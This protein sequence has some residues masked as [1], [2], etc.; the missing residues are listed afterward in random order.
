MVDR[1]DA[2]RRPV[3]AMTGVPEYYLPPYYYEDEI[4]LRDYVNVLLKY[5]WLVLGVPLL[6]LIVAGIYGFLI[7]KPGYQATALVAITSPR[8]IVQFAPEFETVPLNQ[9]QVPLKAYPMLATSGELLQR[10]LPKV[11]ERLP[12]EQRTVTAL[13]SMVSAKSGQ[14][15]SIIELTVSSG[16]PELAA[17]I[18]N[19]WADDFAAMVEEVYGQSASEIASFEEQLQQAEA[20]RQAAEQAVIEFQ[21]RNPSAV[22]QAQLQDKQ[23]ALNSYLATQRAIERV[24]QDAKSLKERLAMQAG[25]NKATLG[26]DLSA[27]MLEVNSLSSS[28]SLPLQLQIQGSE[29]LSDKTVAEQIAFLD[30]LVT[31]LAAKTTELDAKIAAVQPELLSLQRELETVR[32]EQTQLEEERSIARDLYHSLTLKLEETRLGQGTNGREVQVAARALPPTS[33]SSP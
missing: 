13:R 24:V 2:E 18:A 25:S 23:N 32:T 9:R 4:D 3:P 17:F 33:P 21:A 30:N 16:D 11:S 15:A 14:D 19:I 27:L 20:R 22:L 7:A 26:D 5:W 29:S 12:E 1:D 8:Y 6:A 10:I 28:V 31:T